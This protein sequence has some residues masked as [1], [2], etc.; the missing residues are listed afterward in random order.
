MSKEQLLKELAT[1]IGASEAHH[2]FNLEPYGCARKL[3]YQKIGQKQDFPW[4][5]NADTR[6]GEALEDI[7]ADRF[8]QETGYD[9]SSGG[10][11]RHPQFEMVI[12]HPDR[13]MWHP[14]RGAALLQIKCPRVAGY[15]KFK[16]EGPSEAWLLQVQQEM[17]AAGFPRVVLAVFSAECWELAYADIEADAQVQARITQE[18]E[19]FWR[20]VENGPPPD[21]LPPT[22]KRCKTCP[23][24]TTC[25]GEALLALKQA[26]E[27]AAESLP[28]DEALGP[29]V[30]D[31]L[32]AHA[33]C[34][35]AEEAKELAKFRLTQAL[36]DR[37]AVES[38]GARIYYRVQERR[39][40]DAA[41]LKKEY[42]DLAAQYERR[43][44]LRSL[45]VFE[46]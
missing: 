2:L 36:G 16:R 7:V 31:Y 8:A 23:Y 18:A 3:W 27:G 32:D 6:R 24:R 11:F 10:F 17:F 22:D 5:G 33:L 13:Q 25:Q 15:Q 4:D 29:L 45:K 19:R 42:P 9:L 12:C 43:S 40:L 28:H 34:E 37:Q 41:A 35:E 44:V 14:L 20:R 26:D 30:R 1:G 21:R 46:T 38:P 39:T